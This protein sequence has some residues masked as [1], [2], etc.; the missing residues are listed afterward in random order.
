MK[1]ALR[2]LVVHGSFHMEHILLFGTETLLNGL[3]FNLNF[4]VKQYLH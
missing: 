3:F 2:M 1:Q 4:H